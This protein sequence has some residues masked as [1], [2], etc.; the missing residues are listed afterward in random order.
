MARNN[1]RVKRAFHHLEAFW[2]VEL[3]EGFAKFQE[4]ISAPDGI[5]QDVEL[6][7][8]LLDPGDEHPDGLAVGMV[9]DRGDAYP[10]ARRYSLRRFFNRLQ[11]HRSGSCRFSGCPRTA[12]RAVHRRASFSQGYRHSSAGPPG[13]TCHKS[14]V[15]AHI[16]WGVG[17][18]HG[19]LQCLS[20][21]KIAH[22]KLN[23]PR[24][25]GPEGPWQPRE[26]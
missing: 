1:V 19:C 8:F 21:Y 5:D 13:R 23:W 7:L 15:S 6:T 12:P 16:R 10:P 14:D 2:Q 11:S 22:P 18:G 4:R 9:D 20:P 17:R 25:N 26:T 3:P 24:R